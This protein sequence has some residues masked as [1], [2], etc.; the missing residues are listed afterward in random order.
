MTRWMATI[1]VLTCRQLE[2]NY[3]S[4]INHNLLST[5]LWHV[6]ACYDMFVLRTASQGVE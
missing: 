2:L 3:K 5:H 4:K 1:S 6:Q